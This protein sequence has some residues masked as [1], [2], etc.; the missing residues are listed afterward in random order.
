MVFLVLIIAHFAY[1]VNEK[2]VIRKKKEGFNLP[3]LYQFSL[4]FNLKLSAIIAINSEF[5]GLPRLF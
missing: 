1:R 3:F 4:Y 2:A 5:V